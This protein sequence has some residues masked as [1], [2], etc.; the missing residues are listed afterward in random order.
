MQDDYMP[1]NIN[2][3]KIRRVCGGTNLQQFTN[4]ILNLRK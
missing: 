4:I 3:I 1:W 2:S